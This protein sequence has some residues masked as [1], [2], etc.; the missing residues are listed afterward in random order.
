AGF[1]TRL[2]PLTIDR[3]KPAIPFLGK[4]VVGYVA[5]YI[6]RFG[7]KDV[8]VNL[9]HQP[10]SVMEALGDGSRF[11]VNIH[12]SIEDPAILGTAGALDNARDL[13]AD[14]TFIVINGKIITDI[15]IIAAVKSHKESGAVAT[16]VLRPNPNREKFTIVE[17][18]DGWVTGFSEFNG[19]EDAAPQTPLM[20]TG[21]QVLEPRV[22][23]WIPRGVY[24]DIVPVFYRPALEKGE[25][26][27]AFVTD[28]RWYEISTLRRYL[29]IS[30]A[31]SPN[32][33]VIVGE[34][35]S[36]ARDTNVNDS[37]LWDR[38][39]IE[40]GAS[41]SRSVIGEGVRIASGDTIEGSVVV[42]AE[43]INARDE[44]PDKA[45]KGYFEGDKYIVPI[46]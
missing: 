44:T 43:L 14:D 40:S 32:G 13:L 46:V 26:I 34:A 39:A 3:T 25:K 7:I 11:G 38:V 12:Y 8:V 35:C 41:V 10:Q 31:M 22:F 19:Q 36:V 20:Y 30:L 2:F 23:D 4:P 6:A 45:Q 27:N 21:I 24:S 5:E 18:K 37:V 9:H 15:D 33:R 29:D 1:G 16:M 42:R 28:A 17:T